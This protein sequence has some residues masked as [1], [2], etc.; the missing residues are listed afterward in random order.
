MINRSIFRLAMSACIC[1]A[2]GFPLSTTGTHLD[3]LAQQKTSDQIML[4]VSVTDKNDQPIRRLPQS[5]FQVLNA[6][7]PQAI[8]SFDD[9]D[10]SA[11]VAL[12]MDPSTTDSAEYRDRKRIPR[13]IGA[14][15]RFVEFGHPAN[16]Y[17]VLKLKD[18]VRDSSTERYNGEKALAALRS[19]DPLSFHGNASIYYAYHLGISKVSEG[20]YS[21]RALVMITDGLDF[22]SRNLELDAD[23]LINEKNIL[24]YLIFMTPE[25]YPGEYYTSGTTA[26]IALWFK[27]LA[28]SSGGMFFHAKSAK[29]V[30]GF[31]QRISLDLRSRYT[32]TFRPSTPFDRGKC[33][34]FKVQVNSAAHSKTL[35]LRSRYSSCS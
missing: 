26:D 29:D 22:S 5:A 25:G 11:S 16:E 31:L 28:E 14:L 3:R 13:L 21:K 15:A 4:V 10:R 23:S 18:G 30:E 33:F 2:L 27:N 9:L 12:I 6:G 1:A 8:T 17:F 32:I 24:I 35:R 34:P 20:A 19:A 7:L